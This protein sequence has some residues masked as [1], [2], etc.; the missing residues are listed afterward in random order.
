MHR[1]RS[2]FCTLLGC[3]LFRV[4]TLVML[5]ALF[6]GSV[7]NWMDYTEFDSTPGHSLSL[8]GDLHDGNDGEEPFLMPEKPIGKA[9]PLHA[10]AACPIL[11]PAAVALFRPDTPPP[12]LS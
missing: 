5:L 12:I 11:V 10:E 6:M 2:T 3:K 9:V 8:A 1:F 4:A 7:D